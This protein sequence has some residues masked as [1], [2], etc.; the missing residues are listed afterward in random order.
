MRTFLVILFSIIEFT[1]FI[2]F[3]VAEDWPEM[4]IFH[5]DSEW[6]NQEG[7]NVLLESLSDKPMVI[8]MVYTSCQHSCPM[9][10]SKIADIRKSIPEKLQSNARYV[11]ISFDPER[12]TPDSLKAYKARRKLDNNWLLLTSNKRNI[13]QLAGVL[14]VNYKLMKDGEFSHSNIISLVDNKGVVLSQVNGLYKDSGELSKNL[15]SLLN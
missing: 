5:L 2:P 15:Q 7:E 1:I 12:D 13:R 9:I 8:A 6:T 3:A 11:L 10:T 14:G 4:S